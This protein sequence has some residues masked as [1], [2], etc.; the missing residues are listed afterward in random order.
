MCGAPGCGALF[1]LRGLRA[2]RQFVHLAGNL[3]AQH[4]QARANYLDLLM[5]LG[6]TAEDWFRIELLVVLRAISGISIIGTN[7]QTQRAGDRPDFTIE[8][9]GRSVLL[10]LKVLPKDRNYAYGWQRF[11][12]GTNN[13]KD[14]DNLVLGVRHGVIY[15][16]WP[17]LAD[18][19]SCRTN[20]ERTYPVQCLRQDPIAR[21]TGHVV[22]SYWAVSRSVA[23]LSAAG[24]A[25]SGGIP[26]LS[27]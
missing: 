13:K 18:W 12:A 16:Y 11:Q 4:F 2:M 22:L 6:I 25:A 21:S 10:E 8:L 23:Q 1:R 3:I 14:F 27:L 7:Q 15:V 9:S 19:Q 20:L 5:S 24:D 26:G 17:D